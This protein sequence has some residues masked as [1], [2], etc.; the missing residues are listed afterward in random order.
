MSREIKFRVWYKANKRMLDWES[1]KRDADFTDIEDEN[2]EWMQY[3]GYND[4][5]GK[6]IYEGDIVRC[7]DGECYNGIWEHDEVVIIDDIINWETMMKLSETEH[8][9]ILGD[10]Y[11]NQELIEANK[12]DDSDSPFEE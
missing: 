3:T 2:S 4:D 7:Y 9:K 11:N 10:I 12:F 1:I 6:E 5:E 8:H